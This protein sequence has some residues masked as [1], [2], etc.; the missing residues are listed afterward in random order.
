MASR[1]DLVSSLTEALECPVCLEVARDPVCLACPHAVCESCARAC[2]VRCLPSADLACPLC[3][4]ATPLKRTADAGATEDAILEEACAQA[5]VE[6][7]DALAQTSCEGAA[8]APEERRAAALRCA[9]RASPAA[10]DRLAAT[11]IFDRHTTLAAVVER[12]EKANAAAAAPPPPEKQPCLFFARG[13]C[14]NGDACAYS[15]A[16]PSSA[17]GEPEPVPPGARFL[18]VHNLDPSVGVELIYGAAATCGAVESMDVLRRPGEATAFIYMA[19]PAAGRRALSQL[20]NLHTGPGGG[21]RAEAL[22]LANIHPPNKRVRLRNLPRGLRTSA[23]QLVVRAYCER[24]GSLTSAGVV[25]AEPPPHVPYRNAYGHVEFQLISDAA[26][27][28]EGTLAGDGLVIEGTHVSVSFMPPKRERGDGYVI[29][30]GEFDAFFAA[31]AEYAE[32]LRCEAERILAEQYDAPDM[33]TP[34]LERIPLADLAAHHPHVC[35]QVYALAHASLSAPPPPPPPVSPP[36]DRRRDR[37]R[38]RERRAEAAIRDGGEAALKA[39]Y[40][41]LE[42]LIRTTKPGKAASASRVRAVAD[43]CYDARAEYKRAVKAVEK[44]ARKAPAHC[45]LAGVFAIDAVVRRSRAKCKDRDVFEPR[46]GRDIAATLQGLDDA[47]LEDRQRL[48]KVVCAWTRQ[49]IFADTDLTALAIVKRTTDESRAVVDAQPAPPPRAEVRAE[50]I[51]FYEV[52]NPAKVAEVDKLLDMAG[53]GN[54][55]SLLERIKQKYANV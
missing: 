54:E 47:S 28:V 50:I 20:S 49:G 6:D 15:H 44:L 33:R 48:V 55:A 1:D 17:A 51:Q 4:V 42:D 18:I 31:E 22:Q 27:C 24:F 3:N 41:T 9:I 7:V 32:R 29:S 30:Q 26:A 45:R 11:V 40:G 2:L 16:R 43:A 25:V 14:R 46:F 19:D 13:M 5:G 21:K 34:L 12:V 8:A 35:D 39:L 52:H 53:P 23:L 38:S 10:K 37:S 36:L